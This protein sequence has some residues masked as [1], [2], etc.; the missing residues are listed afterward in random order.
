[1]KPR[2]SDEQVDYIATNIRAIGLSSNHRRA[3]GPCK[4]TTPN[5]ETE[6][7]MYAQ[8]SLPAQP[9]CSGAGKHGTSWG[10]GGR[11]ALFHEARS[12]WWP[13]SSSRCQHERAAHDRNI[14]THASGYKIA[15]SVCQA[16]SCWP[17]PRPA[18]TSYSVPGACGRAWALARSWFGLQLYYK[19]KLGA[20]VRITQWDA[21]NGPG[22]R[23]DP[24]A[25]AMP[26][27]L[28]P[29]HEHARSYLY[30]IR[31]RRTACHCAG[32]SHDRHRRR[33]HWVGP[34]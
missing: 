15:K 28:S 33:A 10:F 14:C 34:G 19:A 21:E 6:S 7:L 23:S 16:P 11:S 1:M 31:H 30:Q 26:R 13:S 8:A 25:T 17:D 20:G 32:G 9:I 5:T 24:W 4:T 27:H 12:S 3:P 18:S 29:F 2:A 22:T